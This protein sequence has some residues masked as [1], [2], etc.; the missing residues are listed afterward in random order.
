MEKR[1][2]AIFLIIILLGVNVDGAS[3]K[4]LSKEIRV[5]KN[6]PYN[7]EDIQISSDE[8]TKIYMDGR[9]LTDKN[10][11][12]IIE[13]GSLRKI[14]SLGKN[15][16]KFENFILSNLEE[17][18]NII[19]VSPDEGINLL[20]IEGDFEISVGSIEFGEVKDEFSLS[21]ADAPGKNFTSILFIKTAENNYILKDNGELDLEIDEEETMNLNDLIASNEIQNSLSTS[22]LE[23]KEKYEDN[24]DYYNDLLKNP[25][26]S[27]LSEI[28]YNL[29][30]AYLAKGDIEN[31]NKFFGKVDAKSDFVKK[32]NTI[33]K[34]DIIERI[35]FES[36]RIKTI[37]KKEE[38]RRNS[39]KYIFSYEGIKS[40]TTTSGRK[41]WDN[42]YDRYSLTSSGL[43]LLSNELQTSKSL[44]EALSKLNKYD[45]V[46][47]YSRG[48]PIY[49][50]GYGSYKDIVLMNP[51]VKSLLDL[52]EKN[53]K[54]EQIEINLE[55]AKDYITS[56]YEEL[57]DYEGALIEYNNAIE[58]FKAFKTEGEHGII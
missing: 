26:S 28:N 41:D 8:P 9:N 58:I 3:L 29:A 13:I 15:T 16:I 39:I 48:A 36:N 50:R 35:N 33:L 37:L 46:A 55:R 57:I 43:K 47:G 4:D 45:V 42:K 32:I 53:I 2:L 19:L 12:S 31:A 27:D 7:F 11:I 14:K 38:E 56:D 51:Y 44:N 49:N 25:G 22:L 54:L 40:I 5:T 24:I 17:D 18:T 10:S 23:F 30:N 52:E 34:Q 21:M 20:E 6:H 1:W